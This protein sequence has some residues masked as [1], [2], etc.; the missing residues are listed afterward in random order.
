MWRPRSFFNGTA[1]GR[2]DALVCRDAILRS[3]VFDLEFDRL[4]GS[5]S[6]S[7]SAWLGFLQLSAWY[8][9]VCDDLRC[10]IFRRRPMDKYRPNRLAR[11][12]DGG[13]ARSNFHIA[14]LEFA[15]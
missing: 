10:A 4:S 9:D 3:V 13:I 6:S 2:F 7:R 11:N 14:R 12:L 8:C 5:R 1:I 15:D